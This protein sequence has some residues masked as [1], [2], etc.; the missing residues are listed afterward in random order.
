MQPFPLAAP[1]FNGNSRV[2][3]AGNAFDWLRQGW[4]LFVVNPGVWIAMTIVLL[5][6]VFALNIVPLVGTLAANLLTP[7]LGAGV[8]LACQKADSGQMPEITDLFAGFKRNTSGLLVLGVIYMAAMLLI[9]VVVVLLGGGSLA[10]GLMMG[11]AAGVG[12]AL[13]GMLLAMLLT[14]ALSVPLCMALWFAPAL[15]FFNNMPP[16]EAAKASFNACLKNTLPFLVYGLIVMVLMF[17]AALPVLLG[18]LVLVPV[19]AGSIYA[20]YRDIFVAN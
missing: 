12:L 9:L 15:V 5:V 11:R 14:L 10:S 6:V 2:V 13:G 4:A 3:P 1:P 7:L 20:S 19:L 17:F 8:L 16:V 18:F